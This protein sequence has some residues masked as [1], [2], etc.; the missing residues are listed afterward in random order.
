[1]GVVSAVLSAT[2]FGFFYVQPSLDFVASD[3]L[4]PAALTIVLAVTQV[5]CSVAA[6]AR[7]LLRTDDLRCALPGGSGHLARALRLSAAAIG[8]EAVAGEERRAALSLRDGG[9]LLVPADP[10]QT[11]ERRVRARAVASAEALLRAARARGDGE[12]P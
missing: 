2:A 8:L 7:L 3:P 10:P 1:L 11:T 6:L 4:A 12:R 9:M 5:L